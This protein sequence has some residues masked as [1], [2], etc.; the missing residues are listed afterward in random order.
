MRKIK[1]LYFAALMAS[2]VSCKKSH[3]IPVVTNGITVMVTDGDSNTPAAGATVAFYDSATAVV[4][5]TPKYTA[6]TDQSGKV[7]L[8]VNYIKQYFV[9]VQKGVEKNY[10]S[11]LI[12]TGI[13]TSATEI[14]DSPT[15]SPAAVVGDVK[16]QD[17]NGDGVINI[18]DDVQAPAIS[19]TV[20]MAATFNTTIY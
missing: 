10:F 18:Q 17:T 20:N 4:S 14:K 11:G 3:T 2:V 8:T 7:Q 5:N 13:F 9:I 19:L 1:V 6:T 16:Y 12:P 15:Q